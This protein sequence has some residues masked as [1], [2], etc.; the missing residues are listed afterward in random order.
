MSTAI[1]SI[2]IEGFKSIRS[3]EKLPLRPINVLI[4]ANG[5][6]KSNFVDF[7]R[8]LREMVEERLQFAVAQ[9]GGAD[10]QLYLGPK[11]TNEIVGRVYFGVNGYEFWL[12]PTV[13]NRLIFSLE[14]MYFDGPYYGPQRYALGSGHEESKLK[15]AFMEGPH[16]NVARY[17]YPAIASWVV[18]HFHDTS[19]TAAMRRE[20]SARDYER[21]RPDAA[22]LATFLWWLREN[23]MACY[24]LI[25]DTVRLA[26]PFFSDFQ[27]RPQPSNGDRVLQLEWLQKNSDYPFHPS[28]LSDGTLRF[29][30]LVTALLQPSPP[31]TI[32]LDEPEL[33]L[34]PYALTLLASLIKQASFRTQLIVSTQSAP[35][36]D[37]FSPDD[38]IVV[39]RQEGE[40]RF[41]RLSEADLATWLIEEYTLGEL[42]Q[43]NVYG[44]APSYE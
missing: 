19:E 1:S 17:V 37:A 16:Q 3:L 23:D 26:A 25:R 28:Q 29:I 11:I 27:L 4:G 44:G 36:L 8:L 35:L 20:W 34:H 38:V 10:R 33:G 41:R 30:A 12:R 22:N 7:F 31:A 40:S 42:W 9:K 13:D 6:G 14:R 15:S 39:D 24:D 32:L 5:T 2:T 18:Y 43:K 21:L